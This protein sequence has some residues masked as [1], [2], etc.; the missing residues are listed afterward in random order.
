MILMKTNE[1]E[2]YEENLKISSDI[3]RELSAHRIREILVTA[4]LYD[5]LL[6]KRKVF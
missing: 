3:N 5:F 4:T 1:I 2:Q 6:L